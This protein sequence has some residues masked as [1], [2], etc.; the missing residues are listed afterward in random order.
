MLPTVDVPEDH[1][2]LV[3]GFTAA[4][5][6]LPCSM[7]DLLLFFSLCA[8]GSIS[9]A[10]F[11][12]ALAFS[13]QFPCSGH[14]YLEYCF[15]YWLSPALGKGRDLSSPGDLSNL[16]SFVGVCLSEYVR[17]LLEL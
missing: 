5:D 16:M 8:G 17:S 9:G 3:L 6:V 15:I 1:C 13:I 10:V 4:T 14:T 7:F 11:N 2:L 12:P